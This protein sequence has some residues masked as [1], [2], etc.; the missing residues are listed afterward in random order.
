MASAQ[1]VRTNFELFVKYTYRLEWLQVIGLNDPTL[2]KYLYSVVENPDEG[3][4]RKGVQ[5]KITEYK[6]W[7]GWKNAI[8]W[9]GLPGE[10]APCEPTPYTGD[11]RIRTRLFRMVDGN[12]VS[13]AAGQSF[14][15]VGE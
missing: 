1:D 3:Y 13:Y 2:L 8:I 5:T 7:I 15:D 12:V 9:W 11:R 10:E 14:L 6:E 4:C